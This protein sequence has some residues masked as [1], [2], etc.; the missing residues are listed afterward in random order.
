MATLFIFKPGWTKRANAAL[1]SL[2][3]RISVYGVPGAIGAMSLVALLGWNAEYTAS[4]SDRLEFRVFEQTGEAPAPAQALA[5]LKK[6]PSV[7][8]Y[9]TGLSESPYWFSFTA[10]PAKTDERTAVECHRSGART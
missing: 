10:Q 5:Q 8:H 7:D 4:G 2:L 1:D 3:Y 9:D 6:Q